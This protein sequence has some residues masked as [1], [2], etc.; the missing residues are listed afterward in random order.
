LKEKRPSF[1]EP[2][3]NYMD[4][5]FIVPYVPNLIRV[6]SYNLIR[7]LA[8]R[9][10]RLTVLTVW[11]NE[12]ERREVEKLKQYAVHVQGVYLPT[13]RSWTN[14][15]LALP[16][17]TPLQAMYCWQPELLSALTAFD[18]KAD[19]VHVEHLRG[20]QYGLRLKAQLAKSQRPRPVIWD[21]VDCISSLFQQAA[22]RAQRPFS[23]WL[24]Q[25]EL[26]RTQSYEGWLIQQ[27]DQVLVTSP[28][29]RDALLALLSPEEASAPIVV[30]PNGV[31]LDYFTPADDRAREPATLVMSG[32]MSYH[33]NVTMLL[34]F[35]REILPLIWAY[36]PDVKLWVV[37]KDP[38][39]EVMALA[40]CPSISI[41][42]TV[43]DIR[44]YLQRATI[45]VA[46]ITYGAGIQNKV[47]E[48][49]ACATP[50]IATPQAVSALDVTPEREVMLALEPEAF[51]TTVLQL[52]AT[53]QRRWQLGQAGRRYV[54]TYHPWATIAARLEEVYNEVLSLRR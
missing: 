16:G 11:T 6:R 23:R 30:L 43:A 50:V 21:S 48:A 29:D 42:G 5:L 19:V 14:C 22:Q 49:M 27:F 54:E 17:S 33:A 25:L 2:F 7:H 46:P 41:T 32:K 31:D 44:P 1:V 13:W 8:A 10:R 40:E 18:F 38:P 47:L 35:V 4:I 36:R 20:A 45:A 53:P 34:H 52:L 37:G 39:R 28:N 24:T 9:G 12:Q 15:A 26:D 51:A 3:S